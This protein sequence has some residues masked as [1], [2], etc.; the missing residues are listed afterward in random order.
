TKK[1]SE[2]KFNLSD[3]TSKRKLGTGVLLFIL[4]N[5]ILGSSLFYLPSLGVKS[6]G[7]ASVI[8]WLL[9]FMVAGFIMLYISELLVLFPSSGGTY[10]YCKKAYGR[11]I[12]FMAG[13]MIWLAGNIGMALNIVAAAEYFIPETG[14]GAFA[15][16]IAFSLVW[17]I[18]LNY[19]AFRGIDAG[20]TML[21]AFGIFSIVVVS[22]LIIPSFISV[23]ALLE[24]NLVTNFDINNITPFFRHSGGF[25]LLSHLLLSLLMV[26]EAFFGFETLSYL[27]NEAEDKKKLPKILFLSMLI[28]GLIMGLYVLTSVATVNYGD[29]VTNARP[30][31]VQAL[32][33]LGETGKSIIVFG[34]YLT[35][36]GAAAAWPITSS[37]LVQAMAKDKLFLKHFAAKH[38]KHKSPYKAVYFQ[39]FAIILFAW[40]IFRGYMVNWSDPYRTMHLIYVVIS[41]ISLSLI[42]FTV[43]ILRKKF[44]NLKRDFKAPLPLLGPILIVSFFTFLIFNWVF[45]EGA[46]AKSI[47]NLALSFVVLGIPLYFL[48]EMFYDP[49]AIVRTNEFLSYFVLLTEKIHFPLSIRNKILKDLGDVKGKTVLDYGCS[50]GSLTKRLARKVGSN[51]RVYATDISLHNVKITDQRTNEISQ[52]TVHH[53][54]SLD[55]FSLKLFP[56]ADL[57]LSIG[58]MSYLQKPR[59]I[60]TSLSKQVKKNS[61]IIF[62]D[63]DKFF[64][65]IPNVTWIEDDKQLVKLFKFAGFK[66][67]ITRKQGFL[68]T[69]VIVKGKKI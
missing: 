59:K 32:N 44:A 47:I 20:V 68:W 16:R 37:R 31:A 54:P 48:I 30:W 61:E 51:G 41:L 69:Y 24:G 53:H 11:F 7:A 8:S 14:S 55:N 3:S 10:F 23:P 4:I 60:L 43:P 26:S 6:F 15:L 62:V 52:V 36:I 19:M 56:K 42:L 46:V 65:F 25:G 57:V 39:T 9:I 67:K 5:S 35:I 63:Y 33:I 38:P 12:S 49:K 21:V 2:K 17:I 27:S 18:A 64:Y 45:I 58:M 22:L 50:I 34:M 66:V 13:W 28:C 29:Y 40:L 1:T